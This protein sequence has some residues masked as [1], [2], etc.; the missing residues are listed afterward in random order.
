MR[1]L[2]PGEYGLQL[3]DQYCRFLADAPAPFIA[4]I[5][6]LVR[7]YHDGKEEI[8]NPLLV[9][10]LKRFLKSPSMRRLFIAAAAQYKRPHE[11]EDAIESTDDMIALFSNQELLTFMLSVYLYKSVRRLSNEHAHWENI[12]NEIQIRTHSAFYLGEA[13]PGIGAFRAWLAL[14]LPYMVLA[15]LL[16]QNGTAV[17]RYLNASS[18]CKG[19]ELEEKQLEYFKFYL[20]DMEANFCRRLG[21]GTRISSMAYA[22]GM[23]RS[24]DLEDVDSFYHQKQLLEV[25]HSSLVKTGKFPDITHL[26]KYYPSKTDGEALK[27]FYADCGEAMIPWLQLSLTDNYSIFDHPLYKLVV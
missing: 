21:L 2:P 4:T 26:G 10:E 1:E 23:D 15:S 19:A 3:S 18:R 11:F 7:H 20:R 27:E 6:I 17:V 24:K 25:W 12:C 16:K 13:L 8:D 14:T 9:F 5:R 22:A